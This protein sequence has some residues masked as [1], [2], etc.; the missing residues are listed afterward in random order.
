MLEHRRSRERL[1]H[2]FF[3]IG[4]G[5]RR[6]IDGHARAVI[7]KVLRRRSRVGAVCLRFTLSLKSISLSRRL[8]ERFATGLMGG[9]AASNGAR[10]IAN[11]DV[12]IVAP[13]GLEVESS[14]SPIG[15]F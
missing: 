11:R 12:N 8:P 15:Q 4:N 10:Q 14:A 5:Y 6:C 7:D 9:S 3:R 1:D 13:D 2:A